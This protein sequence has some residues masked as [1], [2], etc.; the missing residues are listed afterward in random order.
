MTRTRIA[1]KIRCFWRASGGGGAFGEQVVVV[2]LLSRAYDVTVRFEDA[3]Y[4]RFLIS[5]EA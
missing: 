5:I 4:P 2:V 3:S 1:L